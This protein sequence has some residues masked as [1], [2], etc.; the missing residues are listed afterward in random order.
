MSKKSVNEQGIILPVVAILLVLLVAVCGLVVWREVS[1]PPK[2]QTQT[3]TFNNGPLVLSFE[4]PANYTQHIDTLKQEPTPNK[5]GFTVH[6]SGIGA[7]GAALGYVSATYTPLPTY[8]DIHNL[9]DRARK[10]TSGDTAAAKSLANDF[11]VTQYADCSQY[12]Y[13]QTNSNQTLLKCNL[14]KNSPATAN[15]KLSGV[16]FVGASKAG[17]FYFQ[18]FVDSPTWNKYQKSWP[19]IFQSINF[20][21]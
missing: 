13:F 19:T 11:Y 9:L 16:A 6:Q 21:K 7:D 14:P 4:Y 20:S 8:V 3:Y 17:V 5:Y 1:R 18:Y 15:P 10:A 2:L 12:T